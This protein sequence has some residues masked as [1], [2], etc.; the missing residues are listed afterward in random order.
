[1]PHKTALYSQ[2]VSDAEAAFQHINQSCTP[3]EQ[4]MPGVPSADSSFTAVV[5][6]AEQQVKQAGHAA[7]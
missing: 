3:H 4:P 2:Q 6:V 1:M 5:T 7:L